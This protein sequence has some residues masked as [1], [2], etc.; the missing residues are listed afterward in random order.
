[1]T[2]NRDTEPGAAH[3]ESR[4]GFASNHNALWHRA[5]RH[6]NVGQALIEEGLAMG[7]TW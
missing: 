2:V 1:L 3:I 7:R 5:A 4:E 6:A